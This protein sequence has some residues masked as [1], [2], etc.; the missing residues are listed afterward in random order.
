[1]SDFLK[2]ASLQEKDVKKIRD[3]EK[4]FGFH[5]MAFE[6]DLSVASLSEDQLAK[7]KELEEELGVTLLVFDKK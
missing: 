6:H 5:V 4:E 7:I 3:F 1:M 2:I